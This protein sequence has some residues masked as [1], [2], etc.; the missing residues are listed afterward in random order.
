M[1]PPFDQVGCV[2]M[3]EKGIPLSLCHKSAGVLLVGLSN[4]AL[5]MF[6]FSDSGIEPALTSVSNRLEVRQGVEIKNIEL[7]S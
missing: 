7:I 6:K 4:G 2:E 3:Q 1:K 5:E